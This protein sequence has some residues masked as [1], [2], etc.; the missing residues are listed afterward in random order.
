MHILKT[1][2]YPHTHTH[3][4]S[5]AKFAGSSNS[6]LK[7]TLALNSYRKKID[8]KQKSKFLHKEYRK[9]RVIQPKVLKS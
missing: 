1:Y 2:I 7:G 6:V 3:T 5:M 9:R 4:D 8:W